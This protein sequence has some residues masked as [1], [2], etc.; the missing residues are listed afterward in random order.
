M[1]RKRKSLVLS[2][3][4]ALL[5]ILLAVGAILVLN[6]TGIIHAAGI[7]DSG[8]QRTQNN[9]NNNGQVQNNNGQGQNNNN[10]Q[11]QNNNN[12]QWQNNNN[13]QQG[14]HDND[15]RHHAR[16]NTIGDLHKIST[17]ASTMFVVDGN[18]KTVSVDANPY[19][20]AVVPSTMGNMSN[21]AL[22]PGD[23]V[24]TNFGA[25]QTGKTLVSIPNRQGPAHLLNNNMDKGTNGPADL[26]FN[27]MTGSLWVANTSGN[28]IQVFD[29]N[30]K[31]AA[32]IT[33]PLFNMPWGQAFNG[34]MHNNNDGAIGA[35]FSTNAADGTIDRIDLIP[36]GNGKVT[37]KIFQIGQLAH[38]GKQTFIAITYVS[39]LR[40]HNE[41]YSDVLV[42]LDTVNNRVAIYPNSST[43]HTQNS[44]STNSGETAYKGNPLMGPVGLTFSPT[45]GDLL[46]TNSQKNNIVELNLANG[47]VVGD[48][49]VDN[50]PV[51]PENGNGSALFG[52]A[53]TTDKDGNLEVYFTDDNTNTVNALRYW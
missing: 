40:V 46:V 7:G 38:M 34:G 24:V 36:A 4:V 44:K 49:Q 14:Y 6:T 50:V 25:N 39:K 22:K 32:T 28:N 37:F 16:Y 2:L 27:A 53:A 33:S 51:D 10:G 17:V 45:T 15:N 8:V 21:G 11:W 1:S 5:S 18:G 35:F 42:A 13:G 30:G 9:N 43:R 19:G 31:V 47:K 48:V 52:I 12:G 41:T 29:A 23:L 3:S 20:I 26:A